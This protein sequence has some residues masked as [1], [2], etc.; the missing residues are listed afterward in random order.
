MYNA[1]YKDQTRHCHKLFHVA[2]DIGLDKK[3]Y[4]NLAMANNYGI[5]L[6]T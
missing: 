6:R 3:A 5:R 4:A 2:V 1:L